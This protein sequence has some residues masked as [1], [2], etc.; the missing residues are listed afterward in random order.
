MSNPPNHPTENQTA[1]APPLLVA[2]AL[3]GFAALTRLLPDHLPNVTAV[4]AVALFAGWLIRSRVLAAAVPLAAMLVSDAFIGGY[5]PGVMVVVYAAL[6]API[7]FRRLMGDGSN[8]ARMFGGAILGSLAASTL[9]FLTT[10]LAVWAFSSYY[11]RDGAGLAECFAAAL[12]FFRY[13]AGGDLA[14]TTALFGGY[15]LITAVAGVVSARRAA[16]AAA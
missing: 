12:P 2:A 14:F 3:V 13:T 15:A 8:R 11:T 1:F 16:A 10:N 5:Q 4:A 6:V 9:F 7:F